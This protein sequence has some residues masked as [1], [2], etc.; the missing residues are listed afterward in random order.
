MQRDVD[1]GYQ[2]FHPKSGCKTVLGGHMRRAAIYTLDS[3][4][5]LYFFNLD[6]KVTVYS[7]V[8]S[9]SLSRSLCVC[10][11]YRD[12]EMGSSSFVHIRGEGMWRESSYE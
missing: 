4:E 11:W 9:L 1:S 12:G 2:R 5:I 10:V 6:Q 3:R 7:L 8:G